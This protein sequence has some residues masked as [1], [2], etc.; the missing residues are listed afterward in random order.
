MECCVGEEGDE[1]GPPFVVVLGH[2]GCIIGRYIK[3]V[4]FISE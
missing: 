3:L 4:D 2:D 1:V